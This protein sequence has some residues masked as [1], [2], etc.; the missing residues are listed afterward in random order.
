MVQGFYDEVYRAVYTIECDYRCFYK[1]YF[2]GNCY[3]LSRMHHR[4]S[5]VR[6]P[7]APSTKFGLC[8]VSAFKA[9]WN[10]CGYRNLKTCAKEQI[11]GGLF[12][13]QYYI[14]EINKKFEGYNRELVLAY[15]EWHRQI[16]EWCSK[17]LVGLEQILLCK[18]PRY[19]KSPTQAQIDQ[20]HIS[21]ENKLRSGSVSKKTNST[22]KS[23]A[24]TKNG[25]PAS[26]NGNCAPNKW[27]TVSR[28]NGRLAWSQEN[29]RSQSSLS[30]FT[31]NVIT[32]VLVLNK[33]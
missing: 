3:G 10:H 26:N 5:C 12:P 13:Y 6:L 21:S 19:Y 18:Y 22:V 33:D 32:L 1:V 16:D 20:F 25:T 7:C 29:Q 28:L 15:T 23:N 30:A 4:R 14:D 8:G 2:R 17:A 11:I 9:D 31:V 27:S 24:S